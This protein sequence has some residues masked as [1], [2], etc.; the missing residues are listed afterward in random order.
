MSSK[1]ES[2]EDPGMH[3]GLL[4]VIIIIIIIIIIVTQALILTFCF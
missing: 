3:N 2:R 1:Y 4:A